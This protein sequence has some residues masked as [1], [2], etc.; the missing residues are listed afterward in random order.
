MV[1]IEVSRR[2]VMDADPDGRIRFDHPE[3]DGCWDDE[4]SSSRR[5]LKG[6]QTNKLHLEVYDVVKDVLPL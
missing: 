2:H 6:A 5:S 3:S 4:L 1:L